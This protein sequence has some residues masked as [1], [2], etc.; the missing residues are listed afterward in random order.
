MTAALPPYT[1]AMTSKSIQCGLLNLAMLLCLAGPCVAQEEAHAIQFGQFP[2]KIYEGPVRT[3]KDLHKDSDGVWHDALNKLV[4][5]PGVNFAGEYYL[6]AH[7]CGT[8]CRYYQLTNLRTGSEIGQVSMFD[9]GDPP[10][11]TRDGHT[12]GSILFFKPDSKLLIVQYEI[13]PLTT[14]EKSQC[15]QR[16]FVLDGGRVRAISKAFTSCTREGGESE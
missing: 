7:S 13:D 14:K 6:A 11:R 16:Y 4:E 8:G 10:P 3:P 12:Y 5:P 9:T 1:Q 2:V 15:R